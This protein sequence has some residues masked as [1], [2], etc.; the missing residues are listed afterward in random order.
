MTAAAAVRAAGEPSRPVTP[1]AAGRSPRNSRLT[2]GR[3]DACRDRKAG[4]P[5]DGS[6]GARR[7]T[8]APAEADAPAPRKR[9]LAAIAQTPAPA[10][11]PRRRAEPA[12][13]S[14]AIEGSPA[15][16]TIATLGGPAVNDRRR[17]GIAKAKRSRTG[18]RSRSG[19]QSAPRSAAD[20]PRGAR[21]WRA[22]RRRL[23]QQQAPIRS[24]CRNY[25]VARAQRRGIRPDRSR[26]AVRRLRPIRPMSRHRAHCHD[27]EAIQRQRQHARRDA[28][29]AAGHD[30]R[31]E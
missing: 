10:T 29:A 24:G 20:E 26:S 14:A 8:P 12:A 16:T 19:P 25:L 7:N 6:R 23:Q 15:A 18:A 5:G 31:I 28:G 1:D 27:A 9:R 11:R 21:G 17:R 30:R 4:R 22:R 3:A 2:A 13:D